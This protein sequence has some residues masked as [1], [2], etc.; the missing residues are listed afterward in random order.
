MIFEYECDAS[1][2]RSNIGAG[3]FS[4]PG[5]AWMGRIGVDFRH[6][7]SIRRWIPRLGDDN[8]EYKSFAIDLL[9]GYPNATF[10]KTVEVDAGRILLPD[11]K[12][13]SV[14]ANFGDLMKLWQ[15]E[16]AYS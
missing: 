15:S 13:H 11:G 7:V 2:M 12:W 9:K 16:E 14:N 4:I 5:W 3:G 10:Q 1:Q 8:G 6:V